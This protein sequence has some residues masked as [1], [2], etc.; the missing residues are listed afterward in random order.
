MDKIEDIKKYQDLYK[1]Y[2]ELITKTTI[3]VYVTSGEEIKVQNISAENLKAREAVENELK[4]GLDSLTDNQLID[5]SG[6]E[7]FTEAAL[8]TLTKRKETL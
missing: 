1:R 2:K 8:N 6:D 7:I 4:N 5:L 3:R